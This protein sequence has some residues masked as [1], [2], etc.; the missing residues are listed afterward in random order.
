[1]LS[2]SVRTADAQ[3]AEMGP[4]LEVLLG[5]VAGRAQDAFQQLYDRTAPQVFAMAQ[6]VVHDATRADRITAQVFLDAWWRVAEFDASAVSAG[7]WLAQLTR[8][9]LIED[10][11][12]S[13]LH[14][15]E[16]D[17]SAA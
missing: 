9:R 12:Q 15:S 13:R 2:P 11:R 6:S 1:M 8:A 4:S 3:P 7:T 14:I 17:A 10:L 16:Q 5:H